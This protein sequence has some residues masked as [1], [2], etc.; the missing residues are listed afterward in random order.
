[1]WG[2]GGTE[3]DKC[4][5]WLVDSR[6]QDLRCSSRASCCLHCLLK[7]RGLSGP[8]NKLS[9]IRS[10]CSAHRHLQHHSEWITPC[11]CIHIYYDLLMIKSQTYTV[12][13]G[14]L[15]RL[16]SDGSRKVESP[17][18]TR[19]KKAPDKKSADAD[20]ITHYCLLG[21]QS[22]GDLI[23]PSH[24]CSLTRKRFASYARVHLF[25]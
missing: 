3:D 14:F 2:G 13:P 17:N 9:N 19:R 4:A 20:R 23:N 21:F 5:G 15:C 16:P 6:K 22:L 18:T 25:L 7:F 8:Q 10:L 1:M 12:C 11:T 24:L